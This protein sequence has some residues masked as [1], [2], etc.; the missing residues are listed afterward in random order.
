MTHSEYLDKVQPF[1]ERDFDINETLWLLQN[2]NQSVYM[3]WGV[4]DIKHFPPHGLMFWTNGHHHV[5]WCL[6]TL[7]W[8]DTYTYRLF[9]QDWTTKRLVMGVWL[10]RQAACDMTS[11]ALAAASS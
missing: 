3:S 10:Y 11:A 4:T 9:N 5:G 6:V 7:A 8:N 1:F 2:T